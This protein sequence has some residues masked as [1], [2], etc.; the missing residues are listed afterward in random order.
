MLYYRVDGRDW[1]LV[2]PPEDIYPLLKDTI[3]EAARLVRPERPE[4]TV[5]FGVPGARFEPMEAGWLSP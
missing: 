1:E 2:P 5:M 4:T 3:R